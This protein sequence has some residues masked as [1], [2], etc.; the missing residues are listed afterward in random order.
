MTRITRFLKALKQKRGCKKS[1]LLTGNHGVGKHLVSSLFPPS[2]GYGVKQAYNQASFQNAMLP[3]TWMN[4]GQSSDSEIDFV[5]VYD[6]E[7]D[8]ISVDSLKKQLPIVKT[9]EYPVVFLCNKKTVTG[10]KNV[11]APVCDCV[12]YMSPPSFSDILLHIQRRPH[13]WNTTHPPTEDQYTGDIRSLMNQCY[14]NQFGGKD[15]KSFT[16]QPT[17][18]IPELFDCTIPIESKFKLYYCDPTRIPNLIFYNYMTVR[19]KRNQ[20]KYDSIHARL[21]GSK[22][23]KTRTYAKKNNI[24]RIEKPTIDPSDITSVYKLEAYSD[25]LEWMGDM[26]IF[27]NRMKQTQD[28][29]Y[30]P[31]MSGCVTGACSAISGVF[32]N[33]SKINVYDPA[34]YTSKQLQKEL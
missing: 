4:A 11:L 14:M 10:Y 13:M 19:V 16:Y 33:D 30:Y 6:L 32:P 20:S 18:C 26:D 15:D 3:V 5:V 1:I 28:Y 21:Y 24:K 29:S 2:I 25:A 34:R 7:R 9:S 22:L 27:S 23:K 8:S 12:I 31:I 17:K